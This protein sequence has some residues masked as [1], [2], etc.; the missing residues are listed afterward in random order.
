[1]TFI[2]DYTAL[3]TARNGQT[4]RIAT[5]YGIESAYSL[6][7]KV[8][9]EEGS[10]CEFSP[11]LLLVDPVQ[12]NRDIPNLYMAGMYIVFNCIVL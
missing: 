5:T 8:R 12:S 2:G 10:E 4:L 11:K 9:C 1:M 6:P 7:V 3:L